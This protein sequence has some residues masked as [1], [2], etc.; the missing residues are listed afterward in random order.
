M[1][2]RANRARTRRVA[3]AGRC[4]AESAPLAGDS[5]SWLTARSRVFEDPL[6]PGRFSARENARGARCGDPDIEHNATTPVRL[7]GRGDAAP[8]GPDAAVS[9]TPG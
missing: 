4:A 8:S 7:P 5:T 1:I 6:G 3:E 9:R 2:R